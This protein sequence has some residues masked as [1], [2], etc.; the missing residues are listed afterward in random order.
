ME[1]E[2]LQI[3]TKALWE[4]NLLSLWNSETEELLDSF[5]LPFKLFQGMQ[6]KANPLVSNVVLSKVCHFLVSILFSKTKKQIVLSNSEMVNSE[7]QSN[8]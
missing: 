2:Y 7:F 5:C 8:Q 4:F 1:L 3:G 6:F